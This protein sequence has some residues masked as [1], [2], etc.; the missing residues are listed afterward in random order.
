MWINWYDIDMKE[1]NLELHKAVCQAHTKVLYVEEVLFV[2]IFALTNIT[3]N[4]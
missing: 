4:G 2:D 3:N 1:S